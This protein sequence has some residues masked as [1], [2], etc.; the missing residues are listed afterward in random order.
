MVPER[1]QMS[2]GGEAIEE[3]IGRDEDEEMPKFQTGAFEILGDGRKDKNLVQR[4]FLNSYIPA[5]M[6]SQH[7]IRRLITSIRVVEDNEF[8]CDQVRVCGFEIK[9]SFGF[10]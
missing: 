2:K 4:D 9:V 3:V 1:I 6:I 5:R 7:T 8:H 10:S